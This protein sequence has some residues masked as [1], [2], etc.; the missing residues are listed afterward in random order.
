MIFFI[1]DVHLGFY[2][3]EKNLILENKLINLFKKVDS[4]DKLVIVGDLFDYWFDYRTVIPRDFFR[5]ISW[6]Y[7]LVK[8]GSEIV[9]LIGNHDF[10]HYRF[11]EKI[12]GITPIQNDFETEFY[13]K[14]FYLSH[15]DGKNYNDNGYLILKKILRNKFAQKFYRILHP[16]FGIWLASGSSRRSRHYTESKDFGPR[17]GLKDFAFSKIDQGFDY[18]VMG[19]NH[20]LEIVNYKNGYYINLGTWLKQPIYGSF[21]GLEFKINHL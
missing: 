3:Y 19:H 5:I 1:S 18:V 12:L 10:G 17:D 7:E 21:D 4:N 6:L 13:G 8:Q 11:F 20:K 14:K 16:D 15:G 2:D 9:Y